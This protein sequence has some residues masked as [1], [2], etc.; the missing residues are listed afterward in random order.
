MNLT[1]ESLDK[2]SLHI[3]NKKSWEDQKDFSLKLSIC[4]LDNYAKVDLSSTGNYI[5]PEDIMTSEEKTE[6]IN[7]VRNHIDKCINKRLKEAKQ[8]FKQ[9]L[10]GE[11]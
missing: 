4:K 8:Q 10:L 5:R 11:D 2:L 3:K 9:E 1:S 6:L 7:F